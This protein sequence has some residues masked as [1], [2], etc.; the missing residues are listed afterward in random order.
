[1]AVEL[2]YELSGPKDAPVVAFSGSLG[3][4]LRMWQPQA[5][6]LSEHFRVLRYDIRGHGSSPVPPAPYSLADLG[7]DLLELLDR[8]DIDQASLCGL[9]IGGMISMWAAANAPERVQRLVLCC[10]SALL[11][12]PESWY[13]RAATVREHGVGE[14]AD[15]IL[16]RWFTPRFREAQPAVVQRMRRI[17]SSTSREGYAGCCEAIA[18][19]DLR[20]DLGSITAP[21]LVIAAEQDPSTPPEHGRLIAD[22]IPSALFELVSDAAHLASIERAELVTRLIEM[23]LSPTQ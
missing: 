23:F 14:I 16:G 17:L 8:L 22:R 12:P 18:V 10:T 3:T 19:M 1:M 11:G 4:D 21:T 6:P 5:D 15:A 9:S 20:E 7:T 13:E 2:N